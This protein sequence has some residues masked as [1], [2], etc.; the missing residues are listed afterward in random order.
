MGFEDTLTAMS[1]VP[2]KKAK[3]EN[4]KHDGVLLEQLD[5]LRKGLIKLRDIDPSV[6]LEVGS[7][8]YAINGGSA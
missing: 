1:P 6:S 7:R 4:S 2:M 8:V 3:F 5:N